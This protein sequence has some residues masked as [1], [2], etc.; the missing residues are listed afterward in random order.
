MQEFSYPR[1]GPI[2]LVQEIYMQFKGDDGF[3]TL[4]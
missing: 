3:E 2:I 1:C 4:K